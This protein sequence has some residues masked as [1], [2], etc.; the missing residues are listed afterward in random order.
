MKRDL[1]MFVLG[2]VAAWLLR[3]APRAVREMGKR[4]PRH[5]SEENDA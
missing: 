3:L 2:L 4:V 5:W 1:L